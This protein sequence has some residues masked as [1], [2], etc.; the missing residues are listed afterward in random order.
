MTKL[1]TGAASFESRGPEKPARSSFGRFAVFVLT[2][3]ALVAIV[4]ITLWTTFALSYRFPGSPAA[5]NLAAGLFG[6]LGLAAALSVFSRWRFL[7]PLLFLLVFGGV[8]VWWSMIKPA[9]NADWAPD[10]ARQVTGQ[11]SGDTLTLTDVRDFRWQADG[12]FTEKWVDRTYDLTKLRSLDLLMSYWAGPEIAHMI[13]SFGFDG[14]DQLAWSIE[15]RRRKDG[16]FSPIADLFKSNPLVIVAADERDVVFVRSNIRGED[17]QIYRMKTA[18]AVA[19][20]LLLEYVNDA[21]ELAAK[22]RFYNSIT[23]NCTTTSIKMM[24]AVG[25]KI[26][27]DWRLIVNGYLPEFAYQRGVLDTKQPFD[28]LKAIAHIDPRAKEAGDSQ[29]F[30]RLIRIGVP[31]PL[32][33]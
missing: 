9:A 23:T 11:V 27:F 4:L 8:L 6:V 16:E 14:G 21:N 15:V 10:V 13:L 24:R 26:S 18:P 25:A 17:V 32:D 30:S 3:I 7:V 31:S 20:K 19:R 12:S 29:D 2:I 33:H 22:P 1:Q 28:Q 5:A